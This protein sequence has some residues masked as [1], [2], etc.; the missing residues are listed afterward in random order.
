MKIT[1]NTVAKTAVLE[2]FG[3]STTA[4]SHTEIQKQLNEVCDRVT[5]Y[6]ILDRLIQDDII[7]KIV[8]LDGTVKYAK[9]RH[10]HRVHIHNHAHF[11]CENCHEI[12]CLENV[13]PSYLIPH[14]YKVKDINFTLSGLCPKCSS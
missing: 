8:D 10:E 2:I 3:N 4:L 12:T 11:S 5:T 9:C 14:S 7:H 13:K 6:R 1:R